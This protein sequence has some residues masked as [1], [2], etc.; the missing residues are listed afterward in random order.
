MVAG[1][2]R[3]RSGDVIIDAMPQGVEQTSDADRQRVQDY[4]TI[5]AMPQGVEQI[6]PLIIFV[7][8][9]GDN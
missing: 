6:E 5:D 2:Q 8:A 4:V 9:H 7:W 1:D 3:L